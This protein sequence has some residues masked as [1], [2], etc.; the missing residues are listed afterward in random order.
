MISMKI[1]VIPRRPAGGHCV[2]P[3]CDLALLG[4]GCIGDV[5]FD[6]ELSGAS[7]KLGEFARLTK[8]RAAAAVCGCRTD[9]RGLKRKSAAVAEGGR[10][11]GITDMLH[12]VDGEEYKS[13]AYLGLYRLGGYKV[14]LCI[15]N[16]IRYPEDI[17]S[18]SLCGCN[19]VACLSEQPD[20]M[21]PLLIRAYAYLY[22]VPIVMVA[23]GTAYFADISGII[24]T[25]NQSVCT[26]ETVPKNAYRLVTSR[27][28]GLIPRESGDY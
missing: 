21:L 23:S 6:T 7:D 25:S 2:L 4:F 13:G 20:E 8:Q 22:G 11:V 28:R 10:L 5:C 19:L 14:G 26:F 15:D 17:R 12:V 9:S 1:C 24:A 3:Q 27:R 18:L 16:D